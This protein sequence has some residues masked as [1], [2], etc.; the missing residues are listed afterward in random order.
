MSDFSASKGSFWATILVFQ[1]V[2]SSKS[3]SWT[4]FPPK[5]ESQSTFGTPPKTNT[6]TQT[7]G[8]KKRWL[9]LTMGIFGIYV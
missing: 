8:L 1:G 7:H 3:F 5:T 6:D 9:L 2:T 4:P